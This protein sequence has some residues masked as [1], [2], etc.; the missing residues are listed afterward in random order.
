MRLGDDKIAHL[1]HVSYDAL[2]KG[3]A[4]E[5]EADDARVRRELKQSIIRSLKAE[6]EI[7]DAVRRKI[8]SYSKKIMEG[9]P[10]WDVLFAKHYQEE[11]G[12]RGKL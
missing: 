3:R 10:E 2:L 6:E 7:E 1:A 5:L 8:Q 9:S 11:L 4:F 12:K